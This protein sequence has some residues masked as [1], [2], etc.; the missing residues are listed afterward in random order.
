MRG[1]GFGGGLRARRRLRWLAATAAGLWLV[2][3]SVY[4]LRLGVAARAAER[5]LGA[6]TPA[7]ESALAL[8]R[9]FDAATGLLATVGVAAEG[10]SRH[11]GRSCLA[12][13]R[14]RLRGGWTRNGLRTRRASFRPAMLA[15]RG[16]RHGICQGVAYLVLGFLEGLRAAALPLQKRV[17]CRRI[18]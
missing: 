15:Q 10:R 11:L 1:G 9:D 5:A 17:R 18:F 13:R 6:L 3:L 16:S 14:T 12:A 8:R 7:V 4:A 2:A